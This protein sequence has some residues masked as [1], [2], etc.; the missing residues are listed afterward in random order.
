MYYCF[1][2]KIYYKMYCSFI[3]DFFCGV[4]VWGKFSKKRSILMLINMNLKI[5]Y[6]YDYGGSGNFMIG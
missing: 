2:I 5:F 3:L 4:N 6:F 1:Y